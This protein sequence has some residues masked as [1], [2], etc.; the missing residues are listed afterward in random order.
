MGTKGGKMNIVATIDNEKD[1]MEINR[2][3]RYF[4]TA[5]R[6]RELGKLARKKVKNN[7]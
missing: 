7:G 4:I 6:F 2:I 5:C 1:A 3:A